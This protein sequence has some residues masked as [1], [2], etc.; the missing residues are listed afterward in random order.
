[1]RF[2]HIDTCQFRHQRKRSPKLVTTTFYAH[3]EG[4]HNTH[5]HT[6]KKKHLSVISA[7]KHL[8]LRMTSQVTSENTLGISC[9]SVTIASR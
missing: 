6:L 2:T 5:T 7:A 9:I 3:F 4:F 8:L 1:M